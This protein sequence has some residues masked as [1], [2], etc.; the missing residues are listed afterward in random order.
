MQSFS[1]Y[2][3]LS[4]IVGVAYIG[5]DQVLTCDSL[6]GLYLSFMTKNKAEKWSQEQP[7]LS[8]ECDVSK[9]ELMDK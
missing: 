1:Q 2:N 4:T 8:T 9:H 5:D 7:N 6:G 3:Y